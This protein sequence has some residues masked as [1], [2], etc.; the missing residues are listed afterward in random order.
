LP[1]SSHLTGIKNN[2]KLV[3]FLLFMAILPAFSPNP[4]IMTIVAFA[5]IH[6]LLCTGLNLL[7]GYA[8]Q[9]SMGHAGFWG[10]GAYISGV[11]TA[12]FGVPPVFALFASVLGTVMIAWIIGFPTLRLKGH[13]LAVATLGVG[14]IIQIFFIQLDSLTGG[15]SGLVNVPS[16]SVGSFQIDT[17]LKNHYFIWIFVA[18]G[19]IGALNLGNSRVGRALKAVNTSEVAA[20]TLGVKT[21]QYKVNVFVLSAIYAAVAGSLYVHYLNFAAPESFG[22]TT[23]VLLVTMVTVGGIGSFWGPIL[24]AI[25]LTFLPEYLRAYEG[26]DVLIY[27]LLLAGSIMFM[28][29]GLVSVF[30]G[31]RL[32]RFKRLARRM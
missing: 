3:I 18:L 32:P 17:P 12:K 10:L 19:L 15:P 13:Y 1:R 7:M 22:F 9:I 28:P 6:V 21:F 5:G 8:G 27:G 23:S 25:L 16:F 29:H 30:K 11:L 20:E 24:G 14:I 4:Y 2:I 31:A 26:L